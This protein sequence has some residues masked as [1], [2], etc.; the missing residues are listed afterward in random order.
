MHALKGTVAI[1][2]M[3]LFIILGATTFSQILSF[4]GATE[5]IVSTILGQGLSLF[6][7]VALMMLILV[8]LGIFVDQVSMMLITLPVFMP[9]VQRLGID[10]IWFGVLFLICMQLGLL[11]PPHGLLLMTMRGVAPPQ[12]TFAHIFQAVVPYVCM[13]LLLLVLIL[14][15]PGIATWL[16]ALL[17]K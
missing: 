12:V 2:G 8:F 17:I 4:S 15:A 5:G 9:I 1:S 16:P 3:I 13:S 11:L 10:P 6:A 7:V 14:V